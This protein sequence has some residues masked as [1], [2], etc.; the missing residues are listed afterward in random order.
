MVHLKKIL[1]GFGVIVVIL[2]VF[3]IISFF[4]LQ[5]SASVPMITSADAI[6]RIENLQSIQ[7]W[8]YLFSGPNHTSPITGGKPI[9]EIDSISDENYII[10]VYEQ[11]PDHTATF[12]WYYINKKTGIIKKEI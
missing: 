3:W 10:H 7:E 1:W 6:S 4:V 9:I 2:V 5:E 8:L 12:G 11:T